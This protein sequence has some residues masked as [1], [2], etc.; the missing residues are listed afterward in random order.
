MTNNAINAFRKALPCATSSRML[1]DMANSL[2]VADD[3]LRVKAR[4]DGF[5]SRMLDAFTGQGNR[6]NAAIDGHQQ[7]TLRG[8]VD[9]TTQFARELTDTNLALVQVGDR[10]THVEHSLA[11]VVS[12]AIE[13][14]EALQQLAGVVQ[15]ERQRVDA[16]LQKLDMRVAANEQLDLVF[17]RWK[18]GALAALPPASR[19]SAALQELRWGVFGQFLSLHP[20]KAQTLRDLAI[21][22]TVERLQNDAD[23]QSDEPAGLRH[24]L[25]LPEGD[26]PKTQAF[27]Q[28]LDWLGGNA[29]LEGPQGVLNL[30]SQW[31][32]LEHQNT[33]ELPLNLPRMASANRMAS[34]LADAALMPQNVADKKTDANQGEG[35]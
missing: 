30:C 31:P 20:D 11:R 5:F 10:L 1:I 3:H 16:Q 19:A 28:G 14:R 22:Y 26:A 8:L 9:V 35:A 13:Q 4:R 18:A 24:W 27:L 23:L 33:R 17:G 12:V 6:R 2:D 25:A 34:L 15:S 7:T 32:Q 21:T 29:T